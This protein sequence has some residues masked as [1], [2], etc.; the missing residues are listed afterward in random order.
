MDFSKEYSKEEYYWG[1]KPNQVL[2]KMCSLL[3]GGAALDLGVG[4]GRDAIFLSKKGFVVKGI[5][6]SE[7]AIKKARLLSESQQVSI[8][9]ECVDLRD[10]EFKTSFDLI[11]SM[12]TLHFLKKEEYSKI[13][14]AMKQNTSNDGFNLITV[15]TKDVPDY[16]PAL[17][18]KFGLCLFK[19]DELRKFYSDWKIV[20]YS[21]E[22]VLDKSHGAPHYHSIASIIA[23]KL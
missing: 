23:K 13:I 12:F 19:R 14:S 5:D 22:L 3:N 8:D 11:I 6:S 18:L 2:S 16:S 15:F 10:F 21:E 17:E 20:E 7:E 1:I 9:L 4:E